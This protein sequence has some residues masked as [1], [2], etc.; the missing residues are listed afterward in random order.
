MTTQTNKQVKITTDANFNNNKIVNAKID[1]NENTI[2]GVLEELVAGNGITITG[3]NTISLKGTTQLPN[4]TDI[5]TIITEGNYFIDSPT[6]TLGLPDLPTT[7][8]L[9]EQY[10][11]GTSKGGVSKWLCLLL[12][13]KQYGYGTY[14]VRQTAT[15]T[16]IVSSGI[17]YIAADTLMFTRILSDSTYPQTIAAHTWTKIDGDKTNL[18]YDERTRN[19]PM[20]IS[21]LS[22]NYTYIV[23]FN[24][25]YSTTALT[26]TNIEDTPNEIQVIIK[27]NYPNFTLTAE[28]LK[29]LDYDNISFEN[30]KIY[31]L[32]I[33]NLYTTIECVGENINLK[34]FVDKTIVQNDL[35]KRLVAGNN[36]TITNYGWQGFSTT[37]NLE[38]NTEHDDYVNLIK[39]NLNELNKNSTIFYSRHYDE[40]LSEVLNTYLEVNNENKLHCYCEYCAY[41]YSGY[42][43]SVMESTGSTVL[44]ANK[45]YWIKQ[46]S[47]EQQPTYNS[48]Y[49]I[50]DDNY[51]ITTLPDISEWTQQFPN[52]VM[53]YRFNASENYPLYIGYNPV[54]TNNYFSG[55]IQEFIATNFNLST[56]IEGTDFINTGCVNGS[57]I[58]AT[59]G[60][61][62]LPDQTG[63]AGKFLTTDGTDASWAE[64]QG[65]SSATI[66][67]F[68]ST[69]W[70]L[71]ITNTILST[72]LSLGNN[73]NVFKNGNLLRPGAT[74]DYTISGNDI[75][76]TDSL[77]ST[78]SIAVINGNMNPMQSVGYNTFSNKSVLVADWEVSSEYPEYGYECSI[79][80][81]GVTSTMYAQV[82]FAPEE[83]M[84]GNYA[85]ICDTGTGVVTI[86]SKVAEAITIP[87]IMVLGV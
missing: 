83:A 36:I 62:S 45:Y 80:C 26:L 67:Y 68:D 33:K 10:G 6:S 51:T 47:Q 64:V 37:N 74:N 69:N 4:E 19:Q 23:G 50:E 39:F 60:G 24:S 59:G 16:P 18:Y 81:T 17:N 21:N 65:G 73:V 79:P 20:T 32:T 5:D 43:K 28:Q 63:Q 22:G 29:F 3:G 54:N 46:I 58:S 31:V 49:I 15:F 30:G 48:T 78:D 13:E 55:V 75:T 14:F 9:Q 82:T 40:N 87:I 1:A 66:T 44:Q 41:G 34:T 8:M 77:L 11:G 25:Y 35:Q 27:V 86:Y 70:T 61:S 7:V 2:T 12:V 52:H 42:T 72:G 38:L 53:T 84:S 76:F 56:A 57:I 85:N 71:D